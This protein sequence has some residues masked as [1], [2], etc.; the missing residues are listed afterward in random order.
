MTEYDF[1]VGSE[2]PDNDDLI[3]VLCLPFYLKNSLRVVS[4]LVENFNNISAFF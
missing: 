4:I 2:L 1:L 3:H